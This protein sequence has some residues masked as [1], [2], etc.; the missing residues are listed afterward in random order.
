MST[1]KAL[2]LYGPDD[3]RLEEVPVPTAPAGGMVI[4]VAA[5]AICGSDLR[6]IKAGGSSHKMTLPAILGHEFSGTITELGEGVTGYEVGQEVVCSAIIPCGKC[7]YCLSGMQNLCED[8]NALSYVVPGGMAEYVMLPAL[9]V[10]NGGVHLVPKGYSAEDVCIAEPCSCAL[11]G[12]EL[13]DVK[14]GDTVCVIGAGPL[15]IVHCLIAKLRGARKV[16]SVDIM[17]N[18]VEQARSFPEID[19]AINSMKE[20]LVER[21]M[22]ETNGFGVDCVIVASPSVIAQKQAIE[23]AGKRCH[24]NFFGGLPKGTPPVEIDSNV[25]HYKELFIHGTSDSCN[26]HIDKILEMFESGQLDPRRII[27]HRYPLS[28]FKEAFDMA[29]SGEALKVILIPD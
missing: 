18:R 20:N 27:T 21:V 26:I 13:S 23:I 12:Q 8:K 29:K 1:M 5:C 7:R 3:L 4:K 6:N 19:V 2:R 16:I 15:G 9:H 25:V 22:A 24:V 10:A 11:N 28:Q 17:D 14:F